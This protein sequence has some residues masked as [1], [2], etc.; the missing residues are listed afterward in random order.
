MVSYPTDVGITG[1]HQLFVE[2]F[3]RIPY[4]NANPQKPPPRIAADLHR[5][6]SIKKV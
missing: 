6:S 1:H 2:Y 3:R 4:L 5:R